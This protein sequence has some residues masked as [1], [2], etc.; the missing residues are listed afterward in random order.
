MGLACFSEEIIN[1]LLKRGAFDDYSASV[2]STATLVVAPGSA[3][4]IEVSLGP[5]VAPQVCDVDMDGDVDSL[6]VMAIFGAR[7][8]PASGPDDPRDADGDGVI[9]ILDGRQC[10][11]QC[12][13]PK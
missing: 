1:I 11:L 8:Q 5:V 9:T 13:L 6:D 10:V 7:N 4:D 12:T 2:T 3:V